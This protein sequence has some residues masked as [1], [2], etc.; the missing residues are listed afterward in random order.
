MALGEYSSLSSFDH[1]KPARSHVRGDVVNHSIRNKKQR[2][3]YS[4]CEGWWPIRWV[5]GKQPLS[6]AMSMTIEALRTHSYPVGGTIQQHR[7]ESTPCVPLLG[8]TLFCVP[9][10]GHACFLCAP[11]PG[12]RCFPLRTWDYALLTG[13]PNWCCRCIGQLCFWLAGIALEDCP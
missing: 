13:S 11:I 10:S 2:T 4:L 3:H 12:D 6:S 1:T 5:I 9:F 7:L 8:H